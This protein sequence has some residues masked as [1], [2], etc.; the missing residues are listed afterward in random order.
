MDE[1]AAVVREGQYE[2]TSQPTPYLV[3]SSS[4]S[5]SCIFHFS[6][7]YIFHFPGF[8]KINFSN[9]GKDRFIFVIVFLGPGHSYPDSDVAATH[10]IVRHLLGLDILFLSSRQKDALC[11]ALAMLALPSKVPQY[12]VFISEALA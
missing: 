10:S 4:L 12:K 1:R 2:H 6:L 9:R 8:T 7:P 5:F 11:A 3:C